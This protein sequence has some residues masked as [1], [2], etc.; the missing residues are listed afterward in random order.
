MVRGHTL[1]RATAAA[2]PRANTSFSRQISPNVVLS[3]ISFG[4]PEAMFHVQCRR[5]SSLVARATDEE[6]EYDAEMDA[7]VRMDKSVGALQNE[8]A[9]VRA[10]A[11]LLR[12]QRQSAAVTPRQ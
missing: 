11:C 4:A 9:G 7:M 12:L 2:V 10:G 1:S 5:V 3:R 6:E 8:L